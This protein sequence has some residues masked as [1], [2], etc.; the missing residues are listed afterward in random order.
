MAVS[1]LKLIRLYYPA[2]LA[3]ILS[4]AFA[5]VVHPL[6]DNTLTKGFYQ[7]AMWLP[8]RRVRSDSGRHRRRK[9]RYGS[10]AVALP[11]LLPLMDAS[12]Q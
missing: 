2:G 11:T 12:G 1:Q 8:W 3:A 4:L 7:V 10:G 5:M 6:R 9:D